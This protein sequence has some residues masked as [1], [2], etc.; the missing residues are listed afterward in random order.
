MDSKYHKSEGNLRRLIKENEKD[1]K[2]IHVPLEHGVASITEPC[3]QNKIITSFWSKIKVEVADWSVMPTSQETLRT[4]TTTRTQ[5][6]STGWILPQS[7][8]R[9]Q[10]Y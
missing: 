5:K 1:Q 10:N 3:F 6:T 7:L 4:V 9:S 8:E 2:H